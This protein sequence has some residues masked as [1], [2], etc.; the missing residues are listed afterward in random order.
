[1]SSMRSKSN[2]LDLPIA[3]TT[4]ESQ[5]VSSSKSSGSLTSASAGSNSKDS[6]GCDE[7]GEGQLS[8][9]ASIASGGS[10]SSNRESATAALV[11]MVIFSSG[12]KRPFSQSGI[13]HEANLSDIKRE[14]FSKIRNI[15]TEIAS[16]IN[17][18][19]KEMLANLVQEFV[20]FDC[21]L[22]TP[23]L[24]LFGRKHFLTYFETLLQCIPDFVVITKKVSHD[25]AAHTLQCNIYFTG[26]K[27]F[28]TE[29]DHYIKPPGCSLKETSYISQVDKSTLSPSKLSTLDRVEAVYRSNGK[30][31]LLCGK[32]E[33]IIQ[34]DPVVLDVTKFE[35]RYKLTSFKTCGPESKSDSRL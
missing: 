4:S 13:T 32:G 15:T 8:G 26:T 25:H 21:E 7:E 18:Y 1:M 6:N 14:R 20:R 5:A 35:M 34:Y 22:I 29:N 24:K 9:S 17:S 2:S 28:A 23:T 16:C 12:V 10:N 33:W 30:K 19:D 11:N 31:F 3:T 27:A